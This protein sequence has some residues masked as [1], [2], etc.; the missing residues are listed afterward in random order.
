M[1]KIKKDINLELAPDFE[2]KP[3]AFKTE[4]S[5]NNDTTFD[6]YYDVCKIE[7]KGEFLYFKMKENTADA[8]FYYNVS[9][10]IQQLHEI[11]SIFKSVNLNELK[12]HLKIL[13]ANRR[14]NLSFEQNEEI[15][16]MELN[17]YFFFLSYKIYFKLYKEIIPAQEKDKKLIDLYSLQK[18]K[19]KLLKKYFSF[20]GSNEETE[21]I[22]KLNEKFKDLVIPGLEMG[23]EVKKV[24]KVV[25][26]EIN[27]SES[28]SSSEVKNRQRRKTLLKKHK[29]CTNLMEKYN[30]KKTKTNIDLNLKNIYNFVWPY[31]KTL[32]VCD[33]ENSNIKP[34]ETQSP[35][36]EIDKKQ[37]GDF[38]VIFN[39]KDLKPGKYK[40][41]LR[42][43][44][45][46]N[47]IDDSY[48]E[49][50]IRVKD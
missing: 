50:D 10:T 41:N 8:P 30:L 9:Y 29:L 23:K 2:K 32:L 25:K 28:P 20:K 4:L 1:E 22:K 27:E 6:I 12:E 14:I 11:H 26:D 37:E 31:E 5:I 16:K 48:I 45:E 21:I 47:I 49:L 46:G 36:Y 3:S 13:F 19:L 40:C 17:V 38:V 35:P 33:E 34:I 7:E 24:V 39:E 42:L 44:I 15:I 43:S 18:E